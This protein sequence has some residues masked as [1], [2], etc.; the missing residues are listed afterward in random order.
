MC[1]GRNTGSGCDGRNTGS[2]GDPRRH[3]RARP[4]GVASP[5]KTGE[6]DRSS[7]VPAEDPLK[8]LEAATDFF[9][10]VEGLL[11]GH[12]KTAKFLEKLLK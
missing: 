7:A 4:K 5:P 3:R 9:D 2:G 8:V 6:E 1:D 12:P 11:E 10:V